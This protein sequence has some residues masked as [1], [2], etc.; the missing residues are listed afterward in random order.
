MRNRHLRA[1]GRRLFNNALP[2]RDAAA[3]F[4]ARTLRSA[5]TARRRRPANIA[6]LFN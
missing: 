3:R 1:I 5:K 2:L 4:V 6:A